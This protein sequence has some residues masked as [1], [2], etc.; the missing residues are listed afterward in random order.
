MPEW[1]VKYWTE[2]LFSLVIAGMGWLMKRLSNKLK[3]EKAAREEL[4]READ[5][6]NRALE[7]G[8]RALLRRQILI[9]CEAAQ[10]AGWCT[11]KDKETISV[12]HDAYA[13][14]GGN[15]VVTPIVHKVVEDLPI[16]PPAR[17]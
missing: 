11:A 3:R 15:G 16:T 2:W 9:D 14:L 4:A 12:M 13:A 6:R 17:H 10:I 5:E 7:D 8:M 1:I